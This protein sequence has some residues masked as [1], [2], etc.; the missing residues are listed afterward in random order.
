MKLITILMLISLLLTGCFPSEQNT[1]AEKTVAETVQD[2]TTDIFPPMPPPQPP[3]LELFT[4]D[5]EKKFLVS[6]ETG[7]YFSDGVNTES[8]LP[9]GSIKVAPY[10]FV[11]GSILYVLDESGNIDSSSDI[12]HDPTAGLI[13][14]NDFHSCVEISRAE[15]ISRG[16]RPDT[17]TKIFKN[18]ESTEWGWLDNVFGCDKIVASGDSIFVIDGSASHVI[19]GP[20]ENVQ[21]VADNFYIH[22]RNPDTGLIFFNDGTSD[23]QETYAT[24]YILSATGWQFYEG[25]YYSENGF[26]WA[27]DDE[28]WEAA[29]V[30]QDFNAWHYPIE[31]ELSLGESP[32]LLAAGVVGDKIYLIECDTGFLFEYDPGVD[33]YVQKWRLYTGDGLQVSGNGKKKTLKP[34]VIDGILYFYNDGA[35]SAVNIV[36][37]QISVFYAGI[38]EVLRYD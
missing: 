10:N 11:S 6:T 8:F 22:S 18:D 28:L 23:I 32:V 7:L 1:S 31:P 15:A 36:T 17:Y 29:T 4:T 13:I 5:I 35:V 25:L 33:E 16:A 21:H 27:A 9:A 37:G 20:A 38:G 34:I 19:E 14:G 24:N 30:L 2:S 12:G 26:T 3:P